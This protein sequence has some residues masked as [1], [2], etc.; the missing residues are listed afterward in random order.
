M[1]FCR[2]KLLWTFRWQT[3]AFHFKFLICLYILFFKLWDLRIDEVECLFTTCLVDSCFWN[4]VSCLVW[5]RDRKISLETNK[6]LLNSNVR[7][8]HLHGTKGR[9]ISSNRSKRLEP[10]KN[11]ILQKDFEDT[12]GRRCEQQRGFG[13]NRNKMKT[14][15]IWAPAASK[16]AQWR[17]SLHRKFEKGRFKL[18]Y[19]WVQI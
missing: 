7:F 16:R 13:E 18:Q 9:T 12:I 4:K 5:L 8:V 15:T 10:T 6:W 1:A 3:S 19:V 17:N 11:V 14:Y 2:S